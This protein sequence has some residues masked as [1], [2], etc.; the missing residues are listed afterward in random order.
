[1]FAGQLV[2]DGDAVAAGSNALLAKNVR[3]RNNTLAVETLGSD[4]ASAAYHRAAAAVRDGATDLGVS[5][6]AVLG[7]ARGRP[8]SELLR[9]GD[10]NRGRLRLFFE[11]TGALRAARRDC[12]ER[13]AKEGAE[14]N[15]SGDR[16]RLHGWV[17]FESVSNKGTPHEPIA[18][19]GGPPLT[20]DDDR[21][22][23]VFF[24]HPQK[25]AFLADFGQIAAARK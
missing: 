24:A 17:P 15:E 11:S 6:R 10:V 21:G 7:N 2:V 18:S 4:G 9:I 16:E 13:K 8:N 25:R 22:P 14:A 20:G 23:T 19:D 3:W 5:A 12:E 1:M